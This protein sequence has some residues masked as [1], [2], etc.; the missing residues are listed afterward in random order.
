MELT[1]LAP[2]TRSTGKGQQGRPQHHMVTTT[3]N[4]RAKM[5]NHFQQDA[6]EKG[7]LDSRDV[8]VK[9]YKQRESLGNKSKQAAQRAHGNHRFYIHGFNQR[10]SKN[11][12]KQ[13]LSALDMYLSL[14]VIIL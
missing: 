4:D 3:T 9:I 12:W 14:S 2:V 10:W 5:L 11:I 8:N 6:N 13:T 1:A 7:S